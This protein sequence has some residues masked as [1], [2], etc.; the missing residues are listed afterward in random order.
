M[1][2]ISEWLVNT[3]ATYPKLIPIALG[4]WICGESARRLE[5]HDHPG[6][7]LDE[8]VAILLAALTLPAAS[9]ALAV[10]A[11]VASARVPVVKLQAP[12]PLAVALPKSVAPS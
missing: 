6:I 2:V 4:I 8:I 1:E 5:A 3:I 9:L 11:W 12:A 10:N 7:V